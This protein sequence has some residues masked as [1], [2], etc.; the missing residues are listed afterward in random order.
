MF[1]RRCFCWSTG[2][3][4]CRCIYRQAKAGR[5]DRIGIKGRRSARR[6]RWACR[7]RGARSHGHQAKWS[8]RLAT[9][10]PAVA[11][12][13]HVLQLVPLGS[14]TLAMIGKIRILQFRSLY[15]AVARNFSLIFK[16]YDRIF[17][18]VRLRGMLAFSF[19]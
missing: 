9:L 3:R 19:E 1:G 13:D 7:V 18:L 15:G 5:V 14:E 4:H 12:W 17:N 11:E 6:V 2:G 8:R 10:L 16:N